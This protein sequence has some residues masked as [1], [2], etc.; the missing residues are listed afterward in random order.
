MSTPPHPKVDQV[1]RC[2]CC[3]KPVAT[4]ESDG[5]VVV[6][7]RHEGAWHKTVLPVEL[8]GGRGIADG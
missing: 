3:H 2:G 4:V 1:I 8:Q 6:Y 7:F 5:S